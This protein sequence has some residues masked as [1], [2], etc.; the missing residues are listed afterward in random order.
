MTRFYRPDRIEFDLV[1]TD[2]ERGGASRWATAGVQVVEPPEALIA[3]GGSMDGEA[4]RGYAGSIAPRLRDWAEQISGARLPEAEVNRY[5]SYQSV[6][7]AIRDA[8]GVLLAEVRC[9]GSVTIP[10]ELDQDL[11]RQFIGMINGWL[12]MTIRE[13]DRSSYENALTSLAKARRVV[14]AMLREVVGLA[15]DGLEPMPW[16]KVAHA[17]QASPEKL[18]AW[19]RSPDTLTH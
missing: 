11:R 17:I 10:G 8:R 1:V 9:D 12:P 6:R 5:Q 18:D 13:V 3:G 15:A 2:P 14:D 16:E 7:A 19:Y 4:L